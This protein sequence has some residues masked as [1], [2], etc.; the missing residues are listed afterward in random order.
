MVKGITF[1]GAGALAQALAAH[2][3]SQIPITLVPSARSFDD[4]VARG[5][6]RI[7]GLREM[8]TP[9]AAGVAD[10]PGT[11]GVVRSASEAPTDDLLIFSTKGPELAGVIAAIDP[12]VQRG[13]VAGLQNG[14]QKDDLLRAHFGADRVIG[15]VTLFNARR[16]PEG[17]VVVGGTG[18]AYFGEFSGEQSLRVAE[19]VRIF[20]AAGLSAAAA[21]DIHS[22]LWMKCVNAMGVFGTSALTRQTS[23]MIMKTPELVDAYLSILHEAAAVAVAEGAVVQDFQDIPMGTN[24][25][26]DRIAVRD[27]IVST[28]RAAASGPGSLSSMA[29]DV[30]AGRPTEAR[31]TFGDLV[32]RAD[33]HGIDVPRLAFIRDLL[34]GYNAAV[35]GE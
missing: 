20:E 32:E 2:L 22:L 30:L 16:A 29:Q 13:P 14:V 18:F 5:A 17:D 1:V 35:R 21:A 25:N 12:G 3:T 8:H 33:R 27:A 10:A 19:I 26:P 4:L 7:S 23:T 15:A 9:V 34:L 11:I 31:E 28:A 24:L 6:I